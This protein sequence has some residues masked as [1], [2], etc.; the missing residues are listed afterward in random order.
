MSLIHIKRDRQQLNVDGGEA[1]Q[2]RVI[3]KGQEAA[4]EWRTVWWIREKPSEHVHTTTPY[5]TRHGPP[6]HISIDIE[7]LPGGRTKVLRF[8]PF[9]YRKLAASFSLFHFVLY[10]IDLF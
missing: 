4:K 2:H 6:V 5:K 7:Y 1:Q 3:R 9:L 8:R 10:F